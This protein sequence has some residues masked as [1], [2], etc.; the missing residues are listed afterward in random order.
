[1]A[2]PF[3]YSEEFWLETEVV[4]NTSF[5]KIIAEVNDRRNVVLAQMRDIRNIKS[6][7][8]KSINQIENIKIAIEN[9]MT[10]NRIYDSKDKTIADL[11]KKI[12]LLQIDASNADVDYQFVFEAR[13]LRRGLANLGAI[14]KTPKQYITKKHAQSVIPIAANKGRFGRLS[15]NEELGLIVVNNSSENQI[16]Y[17]S[18]EGEGLSYFTIESCP[19]ICAIEL[20]NHQEIVL[21]DLQT[22]RVIRIL[23]NPFG[24]PD[25]KILSKTKEKFEFIVSVIY[26]K[27]SDLIYALSS[28]GHCINI[29]NRNLA[30]RDKIQLMGYCTFPQSIFVTREEIYI[31]DCGNPCLHIMSKPKYEK[32][33]SLLPM[34]NGL[35]LDHPA[36]FSIDKDGNVIVANYIGDH[37]V[38]QI[39]SPAGQFLY[40][41][42]GEHDKAIIKP[43]GVFVT[44][45]YNII[46][47]SN[48][49]D[50]PLQIF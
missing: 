36:S 13:E 35:Y 6:E 33:R 7:I 46:V 41:F 37:N 42:P 43:N 20:I 18:L 2:T 47:L 27:Y 38:I 48:N 40:S 1:M 29:F 14:E 31:L 3:G 44:S 12:S 24:E 25:L 34:G 45:G 28:T 30:P 23:F 8:L 15:V 22:A 10:E 39:Y 9:V 49:M 50:Y 4:I 19:C 26:D 11:N 17:F 5:D 32:S 21:S 16:M